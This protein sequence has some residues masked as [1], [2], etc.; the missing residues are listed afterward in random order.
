MEPSKD[1][2]GAPVH[3]VVT[4]RP[5]SCD[6]LC[7][8]GSLL[9]GIRCTMDEQLRA[10]DPPKYPTFDEYQGGGSIL[11]KYTTIKN[12]IAECEEH[13]VDFLEVIGLIQAGNEVIILS[14]EI[15]AVGNR[16][17]SR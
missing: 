11:N 10:F 13:G 5:C 7:R 2:P 3:A 8:A 16:F 6:G 1:S 4:G 9:P 14:G 12:T 17:S 15:K